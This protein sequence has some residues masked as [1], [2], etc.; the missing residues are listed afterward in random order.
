MQ[1]ILR[2]TLKL[3]LLGAFVAGSAFAAPQSQDPPSQD[4]SKTNRRTR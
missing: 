1:E 4:P 2:H 3:A